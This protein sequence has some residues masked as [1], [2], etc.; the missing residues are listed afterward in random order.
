METEKKKFPKKTFFLICS[1]LFNYVIPCVILLYQFKFFHKNNVAVKLTS[2]GLVVLFVLIVKFYKQLGLWIKQIKN[3]NILIVISI[4]KYLV[5]GIAF[6]LALH[7][8]RDKIADMEVIVL[9]FCVCWGVGETFTHLR[10]KEIKRE[11]KQEQDDN[12]RSI[13]REE[14]EK[15]ANH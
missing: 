14:L 9:V 13:V 6:T 2:V 8:M 5:L 15:V 4:V 11:N 12:M 10:N 7:V 3:E 1:I